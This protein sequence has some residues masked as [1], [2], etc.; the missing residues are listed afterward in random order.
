M[1]AAQRQQTQSEDGAPEKPTPRR[2]L[3]EK[4]VLRSYRSAAR[5]F[6]EWRRQAGFRSRPTLARTGAFGL[7]M[8]SSLG[9]T[10]STNSIRAAGVAKDGVD[11]STLDDT[12]RPHRTGSHH[13]RWITPSASSLPI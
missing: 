1:I 5:R 7:K 3:N 13:R 11:G 9:R 6:T 2:M 10:R 4:Q 12:K 8:R